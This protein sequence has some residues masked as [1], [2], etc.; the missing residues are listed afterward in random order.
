MPDTDND[1]RRSHILF[2]RR[3]R[4]IGEAISRHLV[5]IR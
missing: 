3:A 5:S 1:R 4:I 2:R